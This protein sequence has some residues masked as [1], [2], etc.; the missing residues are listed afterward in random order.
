M[1]RKV[2]LAWIAGLTFLA[3]GINIAGILL[4]GQAISHYTGALS[5]SSIALGKGNW[6]ML[7]NLGLTIALFFLGSVLAG[8]IYHDHKPELLKFHYILPV[9]FGVFLILNGLFFKTAY[10]PLFALGM[11][12]QNGSLIEFE[13]ISV[14]TTH[15]TGYLSDAAGSFGQVLHGHTSERKKMKFYLFSILC[16]FAGGALTSQLVFSLGD[17]S[18]VILGTAYL[19][20]GTTLGLSATKYSVL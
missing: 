18:L 7:V 1:E 19:I 20:L 14:R 3:G 9:G 17:L 12:I 8:Y 6:S 10:L 4:A 15:M 5:E 13:G 11:G 16:Y 2:K